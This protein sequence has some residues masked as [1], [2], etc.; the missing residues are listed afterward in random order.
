[1]RKVSAHTASPGH[2][3]LRDP[4]SPVYCYDSKIYSNNYR[5]SNSCTL[6]LYEWRWNTR[7]KLCQL[8]LLQIHLD[9]LVIVSCVNIVLCKS[10]WKTRC[11]DRRVNLS[12]TFLL[13]T[14]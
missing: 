8:F 14:V 11:C 12:I 3:K 6:V 10:A 13:R 7:R 9:T 1:M 2:Q 4:I 5:V